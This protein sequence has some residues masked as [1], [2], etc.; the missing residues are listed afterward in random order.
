M[1]YPYKKR[2]K[3]PRLENIYGL[4]I[5]LEQASRLDKNA[6]NTY[7]NSEEQTTHTVS[8][9]RDQSIYAVYTAKQLSLVG[10]G[11]CFFC[12]FGFSLLG[13]FIDDNRHSPLLPMYKLKQ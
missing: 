9:S 4:F 6:I 5:K 1:P 13:S 11:G 7:N 8:S 3:M 2:G 12:V 10:S